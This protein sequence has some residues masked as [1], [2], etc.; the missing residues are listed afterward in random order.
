MFLSLLYVLGLVTAVSIQFDPS[1]PSPNI[2]H[3]RFTYLTLNSKHPPTDASTLKTV[4]WIS[5]TLFQYLTRYFSLCLNGSIQASYCFA[6]TMVFMYL[7]H[8][9]LSTVPLYT[10]LE[11]N[12][13][14]HNSTYRCTMHYNPMTGCTIGA[15]A[16][17]LVIYYQCLEE[18]DDNMEFSNIGAGIGGEFENTME[19][20][21][22]KY[23]KD[24][25]RPDGEAWAKLIESKHD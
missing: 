25:N 23:K 11:Y 8:I 24:I 21:P 10:C 2:V 3:L 12:N 13:M 9:N 16:T 15:E 19:L 6:N 7:A 17:A 20:K 18:A 22:M 1:Y 5:K 4:R 14:A